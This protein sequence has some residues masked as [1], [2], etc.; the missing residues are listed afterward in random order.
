M[1]IIRKGNWNL[2]TS[3]ASERIKAS[4]FQRLALSLLAQVFRAAKQ[5]GD[6]FQRFFRDS[7]DY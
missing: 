2:I 7:Q 3:I 1:L 6:D 4:R 5:E